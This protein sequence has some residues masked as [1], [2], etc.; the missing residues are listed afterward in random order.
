MT[1]PNH[2]LVGSQSERYTCRGG[3]RCKVA[4]VGAFL[5]VESSGHA[6]LEYTITLLTQGR[7]PRVRYEPPIMKSLLA[8][9]ETSF[10]LQNT[11]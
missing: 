11:G 10:S 7:Q 4:L 2:V 3:R 8:H 9:E 5:L 1:L 6:G